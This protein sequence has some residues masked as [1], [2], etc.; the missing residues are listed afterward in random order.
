MA[1]LVMLGYTGFLLC[2]NLGPGLP[3]LLIL[4]SGIIGNLLNSQF[5][6][7][8]HISIGAS[9]SGFGALGLMTIYQASMTKK[10][11]KKDTLYILLTGLVLLGYFG[12]HGE[13]IDYMAHVFGFGMGIV[14]GIL[15]ILLRKDVPLENTAFQ[16]ISY[17]SALLI[18]FLGWYIRLV[19]KS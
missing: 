4:I 17:F 14:L 9:T 10:F 5:H 19:D 18:I 1:N 11:K 12:M 6:G 16:L 3:W 13:N 8:G 7:A 15:L 2:R